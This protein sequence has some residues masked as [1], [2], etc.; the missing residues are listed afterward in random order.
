MLGGTTQPG[1]T[2]AGGSSGWSQEVRLSE[3][4][5]YFLAPAISWEEPEAG[6]WS[7]EESLGFQKIQNHGPSKI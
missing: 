2:G 1:P 5:N 4:M 3:L 7:K 6:T